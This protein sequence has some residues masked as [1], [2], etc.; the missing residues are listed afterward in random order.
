MGISPKRSEKIIGIESECAK[1]DRK[2]QN[3][4]VLGEHVTLMHP[5]YKK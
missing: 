3:V 1:T 2:M 4:S 5:V